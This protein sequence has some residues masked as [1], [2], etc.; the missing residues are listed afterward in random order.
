MGPPEPDLINL[1]FSG[2]DLINQLY[3]LPAQYETADR[4]SD[5]L[6]NVS[7]KVSGQ[8]LSDVVIPA[9]YTL[10]KWQKIQLFS[11]YRESSSKNPIFFLLPEGH[12]SI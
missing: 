11:L 8:E 2:K 12:L 6:V 5:Y 7:S 9:C 3:T 4:Q 10:P 1:V